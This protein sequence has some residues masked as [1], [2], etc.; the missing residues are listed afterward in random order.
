[1]SIGCPGVDPL[2]QKAR[3]FKSECS[4]LFRANGVSHS[5]FANLIQQI[6]R[7]KFSQIASGGRPPGRARQF[8]RPISIRTKAYMENYSKPATQSQRGRRSSSSIAKRRMSLS[9]AIALGGGKRKRRSFGKHFAALKVA[10][11]EEFS[12]AN[13]Q[14]VLPLA[15]VTFETH[16][17]GNLKCRDDATLNLLAALS[18]PLTS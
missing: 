5:P 7:C 6:P 18:G 17:F 13:P 3:R 11:L 16:A 1:M 8:F 14:Q 2:S 10:K 12:I 15:K 9:R 4:C